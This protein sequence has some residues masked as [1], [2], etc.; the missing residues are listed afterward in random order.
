MLPR[1]DA[2]GREGA[3]VAN[4]LDFEQDRR[5]GVAA[6]QEVAVQGMD[7]AVCRHGTMGGDDCLSDHLAAEN[8]AYG[9]F[10]AATAIDLV[11]D[12]FEVEYVEE[13]VHRR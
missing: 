4:A 5:F 6:E 8:S 13:F 7:E 3:P 2:P 10:G 11:L 1:Q 9:G 12:L